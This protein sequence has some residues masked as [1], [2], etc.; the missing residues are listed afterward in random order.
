MKTKIFTDRNITIKPLSNKDLKCPKKFQVFIN[1]LI[2]ENAQILLNKELSLKEE[3]EF[4]KT[5]FEQIKR[6]QQVFLV[7]KCK[8]DIIGSADISLKEG[9]QKHIGGLGIIIKKDYR[10]IGLGSYLIKEI[11]KLAKKELNPQPKII[12]LSVFPTNKPA[13]KLY[14]KQGFKKA[15]KIPHQIKYQ[16]K[17]IEEVIMLLYL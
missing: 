10:A 16:G 9:R 14:K 12:R 15:A 3:K 13:I 6:H 11:I 17:L 5:T 7:A 8:N 4:L 2:K 1:L